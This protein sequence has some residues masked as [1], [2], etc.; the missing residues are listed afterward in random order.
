MTSARIAALMMLSVIRAESQEP[1][2]V[3]KS[4]NI[5]MIFLSM[6]TYPD[7]IF[8]EDDFGM[9]AQTKAEQIAQL[10]KGLDIFSQR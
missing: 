2:H 6:I 7:E 4:G 8:L 5:G 3:G 10:K 9:P 1:L